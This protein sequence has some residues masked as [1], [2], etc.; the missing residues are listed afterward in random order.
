MMLFLLFFTRLNSL[1]YFLDLSSSQANRNRDRS[2]FRFRR[3]YFE[4]QRKLKGGQRHEDA[5]DADGARAI[6]VERIGLIAEA[7]LGRQHK[8]QRLIRAL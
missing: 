1:S 3:N 2:V 4:C 6:A 7:S 8:H 5:D